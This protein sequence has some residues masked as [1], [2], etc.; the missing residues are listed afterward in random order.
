MS[1][2]VTITGL[3]AIRAMVDSNAFVQKLDTAIDR[4]AEFIRDDTKRLPAVSAKT[5][6]YGEEGIPVDS[7]RMRQAIVKRKLNL[8]TV[9]VFADV[10]YSGFVSEGTSR[11]PSRPFFQWELDDFGGKEQIKLIVSSTLQQLFS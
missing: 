5:T 10:N 2:T 1:L 9:G 11:M 3:E 6:G 7:G 8:L 4:A